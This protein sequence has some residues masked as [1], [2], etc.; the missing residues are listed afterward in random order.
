M[1]MSNV[2]YVYEIESRTQVILKPTTYEYSREDGRNR[3]LY[4]AVGKY[5][6]DVIAKISG[7]FFSIQ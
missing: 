7:R 2:M 5:T 4:G 3:E 6:D 1:F